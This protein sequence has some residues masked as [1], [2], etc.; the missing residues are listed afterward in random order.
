MGM[1]VKAEHGHSHA[2]GQS[3]A[4]DHAHPQAE[5]TAPRGSSPLARGL[6]FRL[7]WAGGLSV[8]L[9]LGVYWALQ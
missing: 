6:A 7:G 8:M 3:H 2:H 4:H 1:A 5:P 9:W